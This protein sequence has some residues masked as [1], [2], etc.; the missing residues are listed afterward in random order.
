MH[1][2]ETDGKVGRRYPVWNLESNVQNVSQIG[3]VQG[4]SGPIR[5]SCLG[6][7]REVYSKRTIPL[8]EGAYRRTLCLH[9]SKGAGGDGQVSQAAG[10]RPNGKE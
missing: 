1:S 5:E 9:T 2:T 8:T 7:H 3:A 10:Q 6:E 4:G